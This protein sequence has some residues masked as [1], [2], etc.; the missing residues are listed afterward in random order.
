MKKLT[1]I[2]LTIL[3]GSV[4]FA[5]LPFSFLAFFILLGQDNSA[6]DQD[7]FSLKIFGVLLLLVGGII[8]AWVSCIQVS[9]VK[10]AIIGASVGVTF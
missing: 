4:A 2:V 7:I 10:S 1:Q 8:G 9:L 6:S 5:I 3:L